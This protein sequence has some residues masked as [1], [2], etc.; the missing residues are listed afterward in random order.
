MTIK[1][2]NKQTNQIIEYKHIYCFKDRKDYYKLDDLTL[3]K[4]LYQLI[5]ISD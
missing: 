5:S 1:L 3:L 4:N 2:Q